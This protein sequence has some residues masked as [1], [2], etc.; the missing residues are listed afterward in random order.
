M[1]N[2]T[3]IHNVLVTGASGFIGKRLLGLLRTID[4]EVR[5]ISRKPFHNY[6]VINCDFESDSIPV[7]S[8]AS[9]DTVFHLAGFAHDFRNDDKVD[10][11]YKAINIDVTLQLAKLSIHVVVV[12]NA[13]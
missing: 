10:D 6:D 2:K 3:G 9:I 12:L 13:K 4:C 8:F 7:S 11:L 1:S 5:L